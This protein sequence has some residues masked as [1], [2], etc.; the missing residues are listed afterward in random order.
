MNEPK[1]ID[2]TPEPIRD[3]EYP[4]SA[5]R[6]IYR[7]IEKLAE[8]LEPIVLGIILI[9]VLVAAT[10]MVVEIKDFRDKQMERK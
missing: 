4:L 2:L 9:F 6:T 5:T 8:A 1:K 10:S 3:W 7:Q